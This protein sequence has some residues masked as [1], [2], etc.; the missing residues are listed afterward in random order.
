MKTT[1]TR[2]LAIPALLALALTG[3]GQDDTVSPL[4]AEAPP[5]APDQTVMW[6][7]EAASAG[8]MARVWDAMPAS[9]QRDATQ[10]VQQFGYAV[11]MEAWE[12][13]FRVMDKMATVMSTKRE[14]ILAHPL[15]Q[16]QDAEQ[17]EKISAGWDSMVASMR[18]LSRSEIST[19]S[20]L[21]TLDIRDFLA[22]T[23]REVASLGGRFSG[24]APLP[25]V[26]D[27][28]KIAAT[29]VEVLEESAESARVSVKLPERDSA[30]EIELT[31]V[32]GRWVPREMA[33]GWADAIAEAQAQLEQM[34][35]GTKP[36]FPPEFK[37]ML[38]VIEGAL[39]DLA[40]AQTQEEFNTLL[41][42]K[43][44]ALMMQQMMKEYISWRLIKST[45]HGS[46]I[47][48]TIKHGMLSLI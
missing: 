8:D 2:L 20:G 33:A 14:F 23:G 3:C 12:R 19:A 29:E 13:S 40:R 10:L 4:P 15:M 26:Q 30:E 32:D 34:A 28:W 24:L 48:L 25:D 16:E 46:T 31:R 11:D 22:T 9:Y 42:Q 47:R 35:A 1:R 37:P 43:M 45:K 21:R 36:A 38:T 18:T 17:V 41:E 6:V 5:D 39:D 27:S 7:A 44:G